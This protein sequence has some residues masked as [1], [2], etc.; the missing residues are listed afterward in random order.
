MTNHLLIRVLAGLAGAAVTFT[1]SATP[2]SADPTSW[3]WGRIHSTDGMATAWGKVIVGQSGLIV[4]GNL[5]DTYGKGC[6]WALIRYQ[7]SRN[8]RWRT[9][10][11]YNCATGTGSF[12]TGVGGVLQIRV[13][14][15][16]G[17][18]KRPVNKCSRWKTVYTQG[19]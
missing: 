15:C 7:D 3:K 11:V 10:G 14:V 2:A 18:S 9:R 1:A 12:R 5:D 4:S 6:S 17:T 16:R 13:Q 8:G 19:G